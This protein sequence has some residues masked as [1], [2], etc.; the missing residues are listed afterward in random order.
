MW[1][2]VVC[3][4]VSTEP[5]PIRQHMRTMGASLSETPEGDAAWNAFAIVVS[6]ACFAARAGSS[7]PRLLAPPSPPQSSPPA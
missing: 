1:P 7:E 3:W 6:R 5:G 2:S 4:P